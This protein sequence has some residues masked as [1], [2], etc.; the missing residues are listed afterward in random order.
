MPPIDLLPAEILSIIFLLVMEYGFDE[1]EDRMPLILVCRRWYA[2][3]LSTPGIPSP[4][5]IRKSTTMERV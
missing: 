2:I 5:R 1:D 3:M 4:L